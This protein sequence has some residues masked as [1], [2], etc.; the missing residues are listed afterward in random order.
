MPSDISCADER[1]DRTE[2]WPPER[3][4]RE[5]C[6]IERAKATCYPPEER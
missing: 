1:R 3:I 2:Q 4:E 5:L 6:E